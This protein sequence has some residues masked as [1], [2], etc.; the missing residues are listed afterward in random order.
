M[1]RDVTENGG[2]VI[3]RGFR[4][5]AIAFSLVAKLEDMT[6]KTDRLLP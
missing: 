6:W 4:P 1:M 2:C 5:S 3:G